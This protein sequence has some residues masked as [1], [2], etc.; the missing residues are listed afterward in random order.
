[1][2]IRSTDDRQ[3]DCQKIMDDICTCHYPKMRVIVELAELPL[4][5]IGFSCRAYD[6]GIDCRA[7]LDKTY[8][9]LCFNRGHVEGITD[10]LRHEAVHCHCIMH[11]NNA[12]HDAG[13]HGSQFSAECNR[14]SR[15]LGFR[16]PVR[17][18]RGWKKRRTR[19][20]FT[21]KYWPFNQRPDFSKHS[22]CGARREA[23]LN[24]KGTRQAQARQWQMA[25]VEATIEALH[26]LISL[27]DSIQP[28]QDCAQL[29]AIVAAR[30]AV[31]D[32]AGRLIDC[33]LLPRVPI[34]TW[35]LTTPKPLTEEQQTQQAIDE[36][37][38]E[39]ST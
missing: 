32:I 8:I 7:V 1:M 10:L 30:R 21:C 12:R 39:T 28:Q 2:I 24:P 19:N 13:Y 36:L 3:T 22:M 9:L 5:M 34:S 38:K 17:S 31:E 37:I 25:D 4:W 11:G 35:A 23:M 18:H 26:D 15:L 14:I 16:H 6:V 29:A 33:G 20:T 27:A